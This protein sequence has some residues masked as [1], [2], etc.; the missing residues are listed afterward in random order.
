MNRALIFFVALLLL[1][2]GASFFWYAAN[3]EAV[4]NVG[5]KTE[6][7]KEYAPPKDQLTEFVLTDQ[8][9]KDFGSKDLDGK[10]WL[11]SFFF[12][13]CPGICIQQNARIAELHRKF[14]DQGVMVVNITVT[15]DKDTPIKLLNYANRFDADH[16]TWRFLTTDKDIAYV[17]EVG[18]EFFGLPA[19]DATH[20]SE[21]AVF[22]R[23]GKMHSTY[24]VNKGIEFA[25]LVRKVEDLLKSDGTGEQPKQEAEEDQEEAA[26]PT[27]EAE[28]KESAPVAQES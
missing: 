15:P 4:A 13:D 16:E 3:R 18:A 25:K 11:G 6:V 1:F 28:T 26:V 7:D 2:V 23:N 22:D 8:F 14:R 12:A 21:V 24:N 19:A 17:R 20:T 5:T 10:V 9:G 27:Q